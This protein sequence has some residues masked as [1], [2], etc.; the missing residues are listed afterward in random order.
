[1]LSVLSY[2]HPN[3]ISL[4]QLGAV[5]FSSGMLVFATSGAIAMYATS[6]WTRLLT[7]LLGILLLV[8]W[9]VTP[10]W[11]VT[12]VM[13]YLNLSLGTLAVFSNLPYDSRVGVAPHNTAAIWQHPYYANVVIVGGSLMA[14]FL[15]LFTAWKLRNRLPYQ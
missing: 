8:S 1:V 4:A 2:F 12:A 7:P 6:R 9:F 10:L 15:I 13:P 11:P 5:V 3:T 14:V